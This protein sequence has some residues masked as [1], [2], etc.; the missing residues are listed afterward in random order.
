MVHISFDHVFLLHFLP[1]CHRYS[2]LEEDI[3]L[4]AGSTRHL[5]E[6]PFTS[7]VSCPGKTI[8]RSAELSSRHEASSVAPAK[9]SDHKNESRLAVPFLELSRFFI[10]AACFFT[11]T[12]SSSRVA[13][14]SIEFPFCTP[15]LG[16]GAWNN[17]SSAGF[18]FDSDYRTALRGSALLRIGKCGGR[19]RG[20]CLSGLLGF[21]R[22]EPH[23]LH[24]GEGRVHALRPISVDRSC[25][26]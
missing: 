25:R 26:S 9:I 1:K 23:A 20:I 6:R 15:G 14:E 16:A 21:L 10:L 11:K 5:R 22:R 17:T 24:H 3:P 4:C 18:W 8:P 19:I 7:F 13:V 2:G 12:T